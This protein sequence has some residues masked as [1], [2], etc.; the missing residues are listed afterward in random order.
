MTINTRAAWNYGQTVTQDRNLF[1]FIEDSEE[2]IATLRIGTYTLETL[3]DELARAM[4]QVGDN[5]YSVSVDRATRRYTISADD[6]FDIPVESSALKEVS[7]YSLT[8]FAGNFDLTGSD[9]YEAQNPSGFQ[10]IPQFKL[11]EFVDFNDNQRAGNSV[12]NQSASGRA[13][14]VSF[15]TVKI[16]ECN[17]TLQ[18]NITKVTSEQCNKSSAIT[19]DPNGV[20]NLRQFM[21]FAITKAQ[22]E[23]IRDIDNPQIFKRVILESTP[24]NDDGTAFRLQEL[25]ARGLVGYFQ[26]GNISFREIL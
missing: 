15:G 26:T 12:V 14:A 5:E 18:T 9:S 3:K 23:F 10:F 1:P 20:D 6:D 19:P 11:Q 4:N 16:M 8:G 7:A 13:E 2:R 24:Q 25:Y 21:E 22:M 17:I